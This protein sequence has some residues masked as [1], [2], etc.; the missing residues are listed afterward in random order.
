MAGLVNEAGTELCELV[1]IKSAC[2]VTAVMT[3]TQFFLGEDDVYIVDVKT[4]G[5]GYYKSKSCS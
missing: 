3:F 4:Y 5:H 2:P 1:A